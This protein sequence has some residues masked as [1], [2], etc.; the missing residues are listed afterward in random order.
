MPSA[1]VQFAKKGEVM[2][3][4]KVMFASVM[5]T[6]HGLGVSGLASGLLTEGFSTHRSGIRPE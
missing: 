5:E 2:K 3:R 1:T 4:V 6:I